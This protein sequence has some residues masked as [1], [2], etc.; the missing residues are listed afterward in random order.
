M[1]VQ[2]II[3]FVRVLENDT[4]RSFCDTDVIVI[5]AAMIRAEATV[6]AAKI[7]GEAAVKAAS[8]RRKGL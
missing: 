8:V 6:K 5:A 7:Q 2:K 4:S 3:D 1:E